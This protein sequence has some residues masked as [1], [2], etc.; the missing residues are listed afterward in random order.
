LAKIILAG[1]EAGISLVMLLLLSAFERVGFGLSLLALPLF[2]FLNIACGYT[3]AV[4]I[5]AASIRF[6]DLNQ[7]LPAILSIGV[8][9]TPVF[10]PT[11]IVPKQ[12]DFFLYLNPM[13]G[14]IKGYRWALLSEPFPEFF[15]WPSIFAVLLLLLAGTWYFIR[16]EDSMVDYV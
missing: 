13:A 8:W 2:I 15:C 16:A 3:V 7:V 12:Y 6:R 4:W 14:I 10:Y 9:V 1:I 11:T 5:N